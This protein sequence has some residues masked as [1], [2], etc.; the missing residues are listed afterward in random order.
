MMRRGDTIIEVM[1]AIAIF[2]A[3]SIISISLMNRGIYVAQSNLESTMA[4]NEID[5]QAEALRFIQNSYAAEFEVTPD[6]QHY[7]LVWREI[8]ELSD[9]YDATN[10]T[11]IISGDIRQCEDIYSTTMSDRN[12]SSNNG[13]VINTRNLNILT[14]GPMAGKVPP[15]AV[16]SHADRPADFQA[17]PLNPRI[18]YGTAAINSDTSLTETA[19]DIQLVQ[20]IWITAVRDPEPVAN[21]AGALTPRYFDMYIRTCWFPPGRTTPTVLGTVVRLYNPEASI[22]VAI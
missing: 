9:T 13:F 12:I 16:V 20:G 3:V 14:S 21:A 17:S 18:I 7:D 5:A 22:N 11:L 15:S 2:C 4:Q 19:I 6:F 1:F 8:Y 10:D